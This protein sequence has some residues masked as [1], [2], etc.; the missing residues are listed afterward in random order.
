[1]LY[2][3][4]SA[5]QEVSYLGLFIKSMLWNLKYSS[6][7]FNPFATK[8]GEHDLKTLRMKNCEGIFDI[9]NGLPV[10]RHGTYGEK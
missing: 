9:S 10:A 3:I 8:L 2:V 6:E 4:G 5:Q 7:V 1:M